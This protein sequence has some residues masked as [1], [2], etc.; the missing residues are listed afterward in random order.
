MQEALE[1]LGLT[2]YEAKALGHL[3]RHGE[4]TGPEMSREAG[5]PFGR[6]YDTLNSLQERGLVTV[7]SGRP[8]RYR[9][10]DPRAVPARLEA[11]A[12]RRLQ[13]EENRLRQHAAELEQELARFEA[14]V[15]PGPASSGVRVGEEAGR[16]VLVEA[17]HAAK[18]QVDTYL[19][20][21]QVEDADLALFDAFREAVKRGV[22]T[23]IL[24]REQD[25][26]Y[27][28]GTPYVRDVL[29]ALLPHLGDNLQVRVTGKES[30][31]FAVL[32]RD[33]VMIGVRNP[34]DPRSYF[35]VV[36]LDD[37]LF[38]EALV[39]TFERIWAEAQEERGMVQSVLRR[40]GDTTGNAWLRRRLLEAVRRKASK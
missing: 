39:E 3:L 23:R 11:W 24:L 9:A 32:D 37:A 10:I 18:R 20:L 5:I 17:T 12:R 16:E 4:R 22:R 35:A 30:P 27:L 28:M 31:P 26:D 34:M 15:S 1:S 14:R 19:A 29:D 2:T 6:V 7:R 40:L 13:E 36:H 33:R 8:K 38:A 21:E 25:L